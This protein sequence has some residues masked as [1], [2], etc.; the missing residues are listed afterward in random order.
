[1]ISIGTVKINKKHIIKDVAPEHRSMLFIRCV[2]GVIGFN[3]MVYS[4]SVLPVFITS[5]IFNTAPFWAGI[6]GYIMLGD[7]VSKFEVVCMIGCFI[8]VTILAMRKDN[9]N[10]YEPIKEDLSSGFINKSIEATRK[11]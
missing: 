4:L 1:L 7:K 2:A 8:G 6:L 11:R 3:S 5:I 10:H 9:Q